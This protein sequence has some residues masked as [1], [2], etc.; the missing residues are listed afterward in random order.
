M[1]DGSRP[2]RGRILLND[3]NRIH[4]LRLCRLNDETIIVITTSSASA[5]FLVCVS[6]DA[7]EERMPPFAAIRGRKRPFHWEQIIPNQSNRI[8]IDP[9]PES[10][11]PHM[12]RRAIT[13]HS[14]C[15]RLSLGGQRCPVIDM[16]ESANEATPHAILH[17]QRT[18]IES[19]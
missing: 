1:I 16:F 8:V 4:F 2:E 18:R 3:L 5:W 10:R 9:R 11:A 13:D 14:L 19:R 12:P 15:L 17:Q 6:C 7:N